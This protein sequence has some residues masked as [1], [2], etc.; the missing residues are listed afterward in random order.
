MSIGSPV[1]WKRVKV[2]AYVLMYL[3]VF[4]SRSAIMEESVYIVLEIERERECVQRK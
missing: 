1:S 3:C 4:L 2:S